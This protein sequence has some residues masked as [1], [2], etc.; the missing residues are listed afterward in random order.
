MSWGQDK[1]FLLIFTRA[2]PGTPA[3]TLIKTFWGV[4]SAAVVQSRGKANMVAQGDGKFGPRGW[5]QNPSKSKKH[6]L[7]DVSTDCWQ[8]TK[9]EDTINSGISCPSE[10]SEHDQVSPGIQRPNWKLCPFRASRSVDRHFW[11]TPRSPIDWFW[12][13]ETVKCSVGEAVPIR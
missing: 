8:T 9:C 12:G 7:I 11:T 2:T 4:V 6:T 1:Q 5:P 13:S 3:S 10:I